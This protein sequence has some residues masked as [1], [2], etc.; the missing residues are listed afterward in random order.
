MEPALSAYISRRPVVDIGN[1]E[2][3]LVVGH[4]TVLNMGGRVVPMATGEPGR[5]LGYTRKLVDGP[6]GVPGFLK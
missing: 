1:A 2:Y 5:Y 3:G 6:R 4:G